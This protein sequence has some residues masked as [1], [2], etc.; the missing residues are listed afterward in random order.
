MQLRESHLR[1]RALAQPVTYLGV[2]MLVCIYC[3]LSYLLITDRQT[4][5]YDAGRRGDN[6]VRIVDQ[7]FAHIF[8]SVDA[9]LLFL[10]KSYQRDPDTFDLSAWVAD[11]SI[12]N[13]L[14]FD[15]AILNASG[16]VIASSFS[17][18]GLGIDRSD[19]DYFRAHASATVDQLLISKPVV[20]EVNGKWSIILSRR[21]TAPDGTFAGIIVAML[22]PSELVK[23]VGTV[24]LGPDGS[25]A[26]V[27]LDSYLRTRLVNGAVDWENIGKKVRLIRKP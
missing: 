18:K 21:I 13:E 25:I 9:I 11:P 17:S 10:R 26:L 15:F 27:G 12:R 1:L 16:R 3:T 8:K 20:L 4:A 7:S 6:I 22:D 5:E 2:V 23:H 24:D 19:R 14:T